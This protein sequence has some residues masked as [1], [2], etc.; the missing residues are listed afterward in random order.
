[1]R[2]G[3]I[4]RKGL[5]GR[6]RNWLLLRCW[7]EGKAGQLLQETGEQF[8]KKVTHGEGDGNPPAYCCLENSMGRPYIPW[9]RK[10]LEK[11]NVEI[12]WDLLVPLL[13]IHPKDVKR[14]VWERRGQQCS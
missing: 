1:M 8:L 9:G 4:R 3:P 10:T 5:T 7:W 13:Q 12:P 2:D 6:W 14:V 11:S